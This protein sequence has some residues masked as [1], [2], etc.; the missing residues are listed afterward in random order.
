[1]QGYTQ[2][3]PESTGT[4]DAL[5]VFEQVTTGTL[6][7]T[8]ET[9]NSLHGEISQAGKVL[10]EKARYCGDWLLQAKQ[11][12]GHGQFEKWLADNC[13][14]IS[15]R[16]ARRYM[17]IA[18]G[19]EHLS[20]TDT[21]ADLPL[22]T[23][24]KL[25]TKAERAASGEESPAIKRKRE[26]A[27]RPGECIAELAK[28]VEKLHEQGPD[29]Y[30]EVEANV[31]RDMAQ[32]VDTWREVEKAMPVDIVA[33]PA[34]TAIEPVTDTTSRFGEDPTYC[35][36]SAD[37]LHQ[38]DGDDCDLCG[39]PRDAKSDP[40]NDVILPAADEPVDKLAELESLAESIGDRFVDCDTLPLVWR[41]NDEVPEH[42]RFGNKTRFDKRCTG[43]RIQAR[44]EVA[45]VFQSLA[46]FGGLSPYDNIPG[47]LRDEA[48]ACIAHVVRLVNELNARAAR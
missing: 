47:K 23:A 44:S 46:E 41:M 20:K 13:P 19:W 28:Q 48:R 11:E 34:T 8:A 33:K 14:A 18:R 27:E 32:R 3:P 1:M 40:Q 30:R 37:H 7:N 35:I 43:L 25:I 42:K 2:P 38:W 21:V 22:V 6:A 29:G 9:I 5:A 36:A 24:T 16:T 39:E 17:T 4:L 45:E 31:L 15:P 10:I 26:L 12:V